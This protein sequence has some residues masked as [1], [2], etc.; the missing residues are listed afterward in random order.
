MTMRYA[1][2]ITGH[3][4]RAMAD[5][6]AKTGTNP[7]QTKRYLSAQQTPTYQQVLEIKKEL[8]DSDSS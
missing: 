1:H 4:H 2:M 8:T 7:A 5:F 6:S 3:L